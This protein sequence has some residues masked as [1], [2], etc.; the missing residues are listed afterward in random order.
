MTLQRGN[1]IRTVIQ[2]IFGLT[3]LNYNSCSYGDGEP[4]TLRFA[5]MIGDI[6]TATSIPKDISPLPFKFYI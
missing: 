5:D 2:D 4:I 3:K 1:D 6:L